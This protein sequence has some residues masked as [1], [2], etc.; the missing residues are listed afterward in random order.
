MGMGV[1][2]ELEGGGGIARRLW[3]KFRNESVFALYT[4]FVVCLASGVLDLQ[5]FL[6]F[7]S[8][9]IYYL[10]AFSHA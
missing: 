8:Q 7:V 3:I 10:Q 4:P 5:S 1:G 2:D 6:H 9:D